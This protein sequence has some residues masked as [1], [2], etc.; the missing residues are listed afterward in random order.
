MRKKNKLTVSVDKSKNILSKNQF[1]R[2]NNQFIS[3]RFLLKKINQMMKIY[4]MN[5]KMI[6]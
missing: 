5:T 4:L 2:L 6:K 1:N 3:I